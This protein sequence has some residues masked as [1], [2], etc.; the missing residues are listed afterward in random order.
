VCVCVCACTCACGVLFAFEYSYNVFSLL[1]APD[2]NG[3]MVGT[4][5]ILSQERPF[6]PI[7]FRLSE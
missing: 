6:K 3:Y 4:Q 1:S 2:H 5:H 7:P